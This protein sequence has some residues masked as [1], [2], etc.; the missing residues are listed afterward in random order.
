MG[1]KKRGSREGKLK[2][3]FK[4]LGHK[5]RKRGKTVR[6]DMKAINGRKCC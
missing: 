4:A 6:P 1:R 5:N 3:G 2:R